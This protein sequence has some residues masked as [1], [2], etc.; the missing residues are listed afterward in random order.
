MSDL[1]QIG[2]DHSKAFVAWLLVVLADAVGVFVVNSTKLLEKYPPLAHALHFTVTESIVIALFSSIF[3]EG[4]VI[5]AEVRR[6]TRH[7]SAV[8]VFE[9]WNDPSIIAEILG[10]RYSV[11]IIDSYFDQSADLGH[12]AKEILNAGAKNLEVSIYMVSHQTP[13]GAQRDRERKKHVSSQDIEQYKKVLW[14]EVKQADKDAYERAIG[15]YRDALM[16]H[17]QLCDERIW[18]RIFEYPTMPSMRLII[19][20]DEAFFFGWFPLRA[21]NPPFICFSLHDH[22]LM[23]ADRETVKRLREQYDNVS[24]VSKPIYD[25]R[26]ARQIVAGV[27]NAL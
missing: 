3:L 19:I 22:E 20:D 8:E 17:D 18:L 4:W 16:E 1:K 6:L 25:S 13:F 5:A 26:K 7:K 10:A 11:R 23:K 14:N 12:W 9:T 21:H 15:V 2:L 27:N 24:A